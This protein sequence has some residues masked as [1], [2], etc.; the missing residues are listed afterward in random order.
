MFRN[1]FVLFV[2]LAS[3][4]SHEIIE[5]SS[6]IFSD[7]RPSDSLTFYLPAV[8]NEDSS[9]RKNP[10]YVNYAQKWY[11]SSLYAFNEPV[12]RD[13]INEPTFYRLLWLRSFH[14]PVCFSIT[15]FDNEYYLATKMLDGIPVFSF[16][17]IGRDVN[18]KPIYDTPP[19]L[20]RKVNLIFNQTIRLD[21]IELKN[22][23]G[24][25]KR[26]NFWDLPS[27]DHSDNSTDGSQWVLE[28]YKENKYHFIERRNGQSGLRA[29]LD[30]LLKL[31][32]LKISK[33]DIY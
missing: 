25:L 16:D 32:N 26:N 15:G 4:K 14:P 7:P 19:N 21:E 28:G 31:G 27:I 5:D 18:N 8:L 13:R 3:C 20:N 29:C 1:Y 11:S 23:E 12:L 17:M 22:F 33:E 9:D 24:F 2:L 6:K 30:Y 10:S